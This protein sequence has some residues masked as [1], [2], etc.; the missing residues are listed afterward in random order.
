MKSTKIELPILGSTSILLRNQG[1][2]TDKVEV[3]LAFLHFL[4]FLTIFLL[5]SN[6]I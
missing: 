3:I 1:G 2:R 4:E 6:K 5:S